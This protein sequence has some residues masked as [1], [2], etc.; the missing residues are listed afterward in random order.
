MRG[1]GGE[2]TK[3]HSLDNMMMEVSGT[4]VMCGQFSDDVI[5]CSHC[6][7]NSCAEC[8]RP[9]FLNQDPPLAQQLR[10]PDF[11]MVTH[12]GH[13]RLMAVVAIPDI[14]EWWVLVKET[15]TNTQ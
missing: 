15:T 14:N 10:W 5:E 11:S 2:F 6:E 3:I 8:L 4:C 1:D 9:Q 12:L 7:K 13:T